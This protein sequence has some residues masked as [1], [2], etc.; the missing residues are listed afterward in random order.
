MD[1]LFLGRLLHALLQLQFLL[2][3]HLHHL[4]WWIIQFVTG[5]QF[6]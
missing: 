6:S 5:I 2:Q 1:L 4:P 3:Y